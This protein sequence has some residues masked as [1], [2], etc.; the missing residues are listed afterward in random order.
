MNAIEMR[1]L[2]KVYKGSGKNKPGGVGY[3]PRW[4]PPGTSAPPS[5]DVVALEALDLDI[6]AGEF[7]GAS[8]SAC[9]VRTAQERPLP[10]GFSPLVCDPR[11]EERS[12]P[13]RM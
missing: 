2:R 6:R 8:S 12:S 11:P 10:L 3:S 5:G 4:A 7:F 13:A 1:A 9:S